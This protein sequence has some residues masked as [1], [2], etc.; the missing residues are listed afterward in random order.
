MRRFIVGSFD[1]LNEGQRA[2]LLQ[3]ASILQIYT[4]LQNIRERLLKQRLPIA[5]APGTAARAN[6]IIHIF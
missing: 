5:A 6:V 2:A 3:D 1:A 4:E